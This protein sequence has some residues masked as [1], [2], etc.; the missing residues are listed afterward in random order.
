[1]EKRDSMAPAGERGRLVQP[2]GLVA[3]GLVWLTLAS[4]WW[5]PVQD[6]D[7]WWLMWAGDQIWSG[8]FPYLNAGSYTSPEQA[9]VLHEPLVALVYS[10][11][12]V[13]AVAWIRCLILGCTGLLVLELS[14]AKSGWSTVLA[15]TPMPVLLY[16]SLSERAVAWGMLLLAGVVV[17]LERRDENWRFPLV[18]GLIVLWANTHGSYVL[19]ILLLLGWSWR[20]GSVA[21]VGALLN[22]NGLGLYG[23]IGQYGLDEGVR[24]NMGNYI[25]EWAPLDPTDP[26]QAVGLAWLVVVLV[27]MGTQPSWRKRI[28]SFVCALLMLRAWRFAPAAAI[29]TLPWVVEELDKRVPTRPLGNPVPILCLLIVGNLSLSTGIGLR[30]GFYPEQLRAHLPSETRI[31]HDHLYGGWLL[32]HGYEVFWDGRNDCYPS[33]VFNEGIHV[34]T[35]EPGWLEILKQREVGAVLTRREPLVSALKSNGWTATHQLGEIKTQ[36]KILRRSERGPS[37]VEVE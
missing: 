3:A 34:A 27:L 18:A 37:R 1:M 17:L 24:G 20:W 30:E 29:V 14:R 32:Y 36:T 2:M 13:D 15:L 11:I 35:L 31:W 19:G 10:A 26:S 7:L 16:F 22:P 23:L 4:R 21:A 5:I 12:G 25:A 9:W 6:P 33:A 28:L 8:N